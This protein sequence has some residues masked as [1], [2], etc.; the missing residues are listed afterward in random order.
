M[1]QIFHSIED[2]RKFRNSLSVSQKVGFVP[3]MGALHAGHGSLAAIS[4]NENDITVASI[5]VNPTQF[6]PKEDFSKYPRMLEKDAEILERAG[7]NV[8]FAP[9]PEMI[10][11]EYPPKINFV[12][13]G[14]DTKLCGAS[15]PGHFNGVIQVV[16]LLFHI[17]RPHHAYFGKKDFQQL[18]II[19]QLVKEQHFELNVHG[20]PTIR[21]QDGLA[22]SS[23]NL[24]LSKE[25]REQAVI[26]SQI[27]F[28]L[29]ANYKNFA[30][31]GAIKKYVS[32]QLA[33]KSRIKLDYF[34]ILSENN[35]QEIHGWEETQK[36]HAFIAAFCGKTRLIDNMP[37][38]S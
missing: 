37:L 17:I 13:H 15:R 24:Y 28:Y 16:S 20:C 32:E 23:R 34:E 1:I 4:V 14:L 35:L 29:R 6:G 33:T 18:M 38:F 30:G 3:T 8:L 25:E 10:Y 27:L 11:P 21:E 22:M 5:F 12:I 31:V 26:L 2:Y 19:R 36:P 7:V 9:K